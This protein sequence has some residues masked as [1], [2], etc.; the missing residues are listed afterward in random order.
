MT[1]KAC[2]YSNPSQERHQDYL[3]EEQ[4][5]AAGQMEDHWL[6]EP[7]RGLH[8]GRRQWGGGAP[9]RGAPPR[10]LPG[11][12]TRL[13]HQEDDQAGGQYW[14]SVPATVSCLTLIVSIDCLYLLQQLTHDSYNHEYWVLVHVLK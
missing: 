13:H 8:A 3:H 2:L 4:H 7:G 10:L 6:G 9:L 5:P 14:P 11:H 1:S 12:E